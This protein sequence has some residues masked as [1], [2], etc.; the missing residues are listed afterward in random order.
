MKVFAVEH[1]KKDLTLRVLVKSRVKRILP[2][3]YQERS[4][5]LVAVFGKLLCCFN[6][7]GDYDGDSAYDIGDYFLTAR[8]LRHLFLDLEA[9]AVPER[10]GIL[11][12]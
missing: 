7:I 5:V 8:E 2:A 10:N 11:G 9:P 1:G 4:R 3:W 12:V 6:Y